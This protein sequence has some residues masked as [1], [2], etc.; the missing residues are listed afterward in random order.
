VDANARHCLCFGHDESL[1]GLTVPSTVTFQRT[2][3]HRCCLLGTHQRLGHLWPACRDNSRS[4]PTFTDREAAL[5]F[6][7]TLTTALGF[8]STHTHL[9][10]PWARDLLCRT[11]PLTA[12]TE[13][14]DRVSAPLPA[15]QYGTCDGDLAYRL[16]IWGTHRR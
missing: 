2:T 1:P 14:L 16:R 3:R 15:M 4:V 9:S 5:T 10:Q 11:A 7:W 13:S 8:G 6:D 12:G